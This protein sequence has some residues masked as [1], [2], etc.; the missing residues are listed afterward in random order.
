VIFVELLLLF[1]SLPDAD[2]DCVRRI[3]E[4][5]EHAF[6]DLFDRYH[7]ALYRYLLH[8]N[9]HPDVAEDL[10]QQTFVMVWERRDTLRE[11]G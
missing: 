10:V 8:R 5:D 1:A 3:R 4:G 9:V 7:G 6:R 11:D 2:G